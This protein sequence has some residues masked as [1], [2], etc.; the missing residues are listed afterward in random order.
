M[1][2]RRLKIGKLGEKV[3]LKYLINRGYR[4]LAQNY[5]IRADEIDLIAKAADGTLVFVEVKSMQ[6]KAEHNWP[7]SLKPEDNATQKK[8]HKLKRACSLFCGRYPNL[9]LEDQGWRI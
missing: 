6:R 2:N 9:I 4:I 1:L 3:A 8:I 5:R 7:E